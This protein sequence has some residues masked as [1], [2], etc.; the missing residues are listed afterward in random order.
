MSLFWWRAWV[1]Y[2]MPVL[3]TAAITGV[4]SLASQIFKKDEPTPEEQ[5]EKGR[6]WYKML[7]DFVVNERT[8]QQLASTWRDQL[9]F[10]QKSTKQRF[11][12]NNII[13]KSRDE[14]INALVGKI[15]DELLKGGFDS[16]SKETILSGMGA[17][18]L[19]AES[20]ASLGAVS[21]GLSSDIFLPDKSVEE[22]KE[23]R[24]FFFVGAVLLLTVGVFVFLFFKRKKR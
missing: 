1:L 14:I 3:T 6:V 8:P 17:G 10:A 23:S 9:P 24:I 13:G 5:A 19:S 22:A 18:V 2:N 20:P 4:I 7:R 21:A 16:V 11:V 15:N 12:E